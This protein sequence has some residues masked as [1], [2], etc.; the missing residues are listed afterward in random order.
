MVALSFL[1]ADDINTELRFLSSEDAWEELGSSQLQADKEDV[2]TEKRLTGNDVGATVFIF[3]LF[4][5][6]YVQYTVHYC[7]I[8]C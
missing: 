6:F 1:A 7:M 2:A 5:E 4:Y 3:I 8:G